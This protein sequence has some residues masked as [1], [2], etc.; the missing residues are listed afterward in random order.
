VVR[1]TLSKDKAQHG[2]YARRRHVDQQSNRK[3][4]P[5]I[6]P[7]GGHDL[8][9]KLSPDQYRLSVPDSDPAPLY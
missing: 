3:H 1:G 6:K 5:S 2:H 7:G 9:Y 4:H 8:F